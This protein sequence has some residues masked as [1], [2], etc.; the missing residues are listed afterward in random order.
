ME[1]GIMLRKEDVEFGQFKEFAFGA[2]EKAHAALEGGPMFRA[3][4]SY[5]PQSPVIP[6]AQ[7]SHS[8]SL[9]GY[10]HVH[11]P[12]GVHLIKSQ[13]NCLCT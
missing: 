8:S 9:Y 1:G 11:V 5:G 13:I 12:T 7:E 10:L 6:A 3:L 4:R 2:G